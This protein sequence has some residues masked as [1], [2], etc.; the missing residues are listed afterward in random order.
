MLKD[1][2]LRIFDILGK[3]LEDKGILLA[4]D[5]DHLI[6]KLELA[7]ANDSEMRKSSQSGQIQG[8]DRLGQRAFPFLQLLQS[9]QK[10]KAYI[11]WGD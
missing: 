2:T 4:Q 10:N 3:D 11:V 9:A 1:L 6:L 7:I 8:L 5:L